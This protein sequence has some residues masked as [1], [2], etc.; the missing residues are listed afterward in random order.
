MKRLTI[1]THNYKNELIN[2]IKNLTQNNLC[3]IS[4]ATSYAV[5][6]TYTNSKDFIAT[7]LSLLYTIAMQEN[8]VY[9]YSPK[10]KNLAASLQNPELHNTELKRLENF[11]KSNKELNLEGYVTFRMENYSAKLD[12]IL[13]EIIKKI[14]IVK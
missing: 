14:K 4:I 8:P 5:K 1:H 10:L 13:Y 2:F 11:I 6:L 12:M 7:L 9:R 3:N